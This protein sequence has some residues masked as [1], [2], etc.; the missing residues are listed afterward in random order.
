M[1][2]PDVGGGDT[3]MEGTVVKRGVGAR[4]IIGDGGRGVLTR[5][6]RDTVC[7]S[8]GP[9]GEASGDD[10]EER[11]EGAWGGVLD[12]CL[13]IEVFGVVDFD[14]ADIFERRHY[15]ASNLINT[16]IGDM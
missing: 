8:R 9:I 12:R 3:L 13:G 14:G 4:L 6:G 1:A 10:R 15:L 16:K 7:R 5:S 11:F 2:V